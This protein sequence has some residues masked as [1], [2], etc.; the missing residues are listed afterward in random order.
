MTPLA[1]P[2]P[3]FLQN[4]TSK[5]LLPSVSPSLASQP[6]ARGFAPPYT[7]TTPPEASGISPSVIRVVTS[8]PHPAVPSCHMASS[9]KAVIVRCCPGGAQPLGWTVLLISVPVMS[10]PSY[11]SSASLRLSFFIWKMG[12]ITAPASQF[13]MRINK[14]SHEKNLVLH[15]SQ[16]PLNR[17]QL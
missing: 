14:F 9:F 16:V 8:H 11:I 7:E 1:A 5:N 6:T 2:S 13:I 10:L 12:L 15:A 3:S 17:S 4:K